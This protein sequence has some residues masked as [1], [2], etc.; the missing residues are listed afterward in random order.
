[1]SKWIVKVDVG[2]S[3]RIFK[4]DDLHDLGYN[5]IPYK[6]SIIETMKETFDKNEQ[7]YIANCIAE[8]INPDGENYTDRGIFVLVG[9]KK[10]DNRTFAVLFGIL[11]GNIVIIGVCPDYFSDLV[12][13][14]NT[15]LDTF[16][17]SILTFPDLWK[18]ASLMFTSKR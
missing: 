2:D 16:L 17:I 5:Y 3:Y 6:D 11:K 4:F 14:D 18:F 7:Y 1:M 9:T 12:R 13:E 10:E 15:S 8:I